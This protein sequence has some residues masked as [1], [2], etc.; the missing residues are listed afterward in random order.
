M[1]PQSVPQL[2][3]GK[4]VSPPT[5]DSWGGVMGG[6]RK[7]SLRGEVLST[8]RQPGTSAQGRHPRPRPPAPPARRPGP[9]QLRPVVA[10]S[11]PSLAGPGT[12]R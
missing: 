8:A 9:R 11:P 10:L 7:P 1:S 5:G 3:T 6:L 4:S 12:Q 2:G